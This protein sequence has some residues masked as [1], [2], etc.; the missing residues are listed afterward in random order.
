MEEISKIHKGMNQTLEIGFEFD[1]GV[2]FQDASRT[3]TASG[4][5]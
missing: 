4:C 5:C 2:L 3:Y 1:E